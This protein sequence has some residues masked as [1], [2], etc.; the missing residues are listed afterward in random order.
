MRLWCRDRQ[1]L[2]EWNV[3]NCGYLDYSEVEQWLD[4][5]T[6]DFAKSRP[7]RAEVE[8]IIME[9]NSDRDEVHGPDRTYQTIKS[10]TILPEH[11]GRAA[12]AWIE[13][14]EALPQ[15]QAIF[16][17]FDRD[18]DGVLSKEEFQV[19]LT[20]LNELEPVSEEDVATVIKNSDI[21]GHGNIAA[22]NLPKAIAAWSA[23]D[24]KKRKQAEATASTC[25]VC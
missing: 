21:V 7:Q 20:D 24:K 6:I 16:D 19:F 5:M 4:D 10:T 25:C 23:L 8:Y 11:F 2:K 13:Y 17:K 22:I 14:Q 1:V 15:I 9:A 18:Q 3:K 12:D